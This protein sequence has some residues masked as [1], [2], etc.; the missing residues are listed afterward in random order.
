MLATIHHLA[1]NHKLPLSRNCH[2]AKKSLSKKKIQTPINAIRSIAPIRK[3]DSKTKLNTRKA[4]PYAS[5]QIT[6]QAYS[7]AIQKS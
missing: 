5:T 2:I 1:S 4:V 3:V 6:S 7:E